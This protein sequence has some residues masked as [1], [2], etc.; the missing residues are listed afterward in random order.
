MTVAPAVIHCVLASVR[1]CIAIIQNERE[2]EK[3]RERKREREGGKKRK[4]KRER[5]RERVTESEREYIVGQYH[6]IF[7]PHVQGIVKL[8]YLVRTYSLAHARIPTFTSLSR[9][10]CIN[11]PC[12]YTCIPTYHTIPTCAYSSNNSCPHSYGNCVNHS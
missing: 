6:S 3:E 10:A 5:E 11:C 7:L 1:P 2:G 12:V 4:R 8:T 9:S